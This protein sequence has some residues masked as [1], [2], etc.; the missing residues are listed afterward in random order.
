MTQVD[1]NDAGPWGRYDRN[2]VITTRPFDEVLAEAAAKEGVPLGPR[3][4]RDAGG[5]GGRA[6]TP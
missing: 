3:L 5:R 2:R 1:Y 4:E 6:R